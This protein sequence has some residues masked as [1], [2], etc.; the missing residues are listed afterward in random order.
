MVGEGEHRKRAGARLGAEAGS[1]DREQP[2]LLLTDL[3]NDFEELTALFPFE[4][5]KQSWL[6]AYLLSAG[7]SQIVEDYLYADG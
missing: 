5:R 6:N 4:L 1:E 2:G 7:M 3:L